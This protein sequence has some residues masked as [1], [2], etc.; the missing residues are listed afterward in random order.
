MPLVKHFEE[1][2]EVHCDLLYVLLAE[3]VQVEVVANV[4]HPLEVAAVSCLA[5]V[6]LHL[7]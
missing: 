7:V 6:D 1:V 5:Q 2:Y 4:W 3:L